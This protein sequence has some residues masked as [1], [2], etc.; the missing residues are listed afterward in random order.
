MDWINTFQQLMFPVP[1]KDVRLERAHTLKYRNLP[2]KIYRYVKLSERNL[3]AIRSG[4][5]WLSNPE[6]YNDPYD[7]VFTFDYLSLSSH[8]LKLGNFD[9]ICDNLPELTAVLRPRRDDILGSRNPWEEIQNLILDQEEDESKKKEIKKVVNRIL[10]MQMDA[11]IERSYRKAMRALKVCS[12]STRY[13][14]LLMWAHYADNHKGICIEYNTTEFEYSDYRARFLFPVIYT[15]KLL[16]VTDLLVG[17]SKDINI[18][19]YTL[20]SLCKSECWSYEH[21]WRLVF[22]HGVIENEQS[23]H[24][25]RPSRV[26]LGS[27]IDSS[28]QRK[29]EEIAVETGIEL[30]KMVLSKCHYQLEDR[31]LRDAIPLFSSD[32]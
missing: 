10:Q 30:K 3:D 31:D 5:I 28:D 1:R 6:K 15:D 8:L 32:E 24:Y 19:R 21:E 14:S 16:D 26:Y 22:P 18:Y 25:N 2:P 20:S 17:D 12:F 23:Y 7:S 29:I 13:D 9:I 11:M 27:R 4:D